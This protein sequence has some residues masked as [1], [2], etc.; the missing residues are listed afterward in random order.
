MNTKLIVIGISLLVSVLVANVILGPEIGKKEL[1][2]GATKNDVLREVNNAKEY[3][4]KT[5]EWMGENG[6]GSDIGY[7]NPPE[8]NKKNEDPKIDVLK[9]FIAG[10][11]ADDM[12]IFLSSFNPESISKDLFQSEVED[13]TKIAEEIMSRISRDGQIKDVQ[14]KLEKGAFNS[15]ERNKISVTLTYKDNQNAKVKLDIIPLSDAH[16]DDKESIYVIATSAWKII[17]QVE[18]STN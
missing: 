10:L 18:K 7:F 3:V 9:Y 4:N 16:H 6:E 1:A 15:G 2:L 12:D 17:K 5:S 11:L 8:E 13:K 14:Y